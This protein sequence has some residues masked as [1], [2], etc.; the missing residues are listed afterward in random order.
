MNTN[1]YIE[2]IR[3]TIN[4]TASAREHLSD[5]RITRA[6]SQA[7]RVYSSFRPMTNTAT[8]SA[9]TD[10]REYSLPSLWENYFSEIL[11]VSYP[12]T[13]SLA[14]RDIIMLRKADY[15]IPDET[16]KR[17]RFNVSLLTGYKYKL[18]YSCTHYASSVPTVDVNDVC[19]YAAGVCCLQIAARFA[20]IDEPTLGA[21]FAPYRSKAKE[22][23][24]LGK[25]LKK[26]AYLQW[27][28]TSKRSKAVGSYHELDS[29][30]D[31]Y[32]HRT[33][34]PERQDLGQGEL[35]SGDNNG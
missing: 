32:P 33:E 15:S 6:L 14:T 30:K 22:W 31:V 35:P 11:K 23:F 24:A 26:Q 28:R 7:L 13:S 25:D 27:D 9:T 8:A 1:D 21:D 10:V 4:D 12:A 17:I 34:Y 29:G 2:I 3:E 18:F 16:A 5:G 19:D 20:R